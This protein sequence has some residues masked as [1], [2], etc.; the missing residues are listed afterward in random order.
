MVVVDVLWSDPKVNHGCTMNIFRGGGVYF[1]PDVT[2]HFLT[3]SNLRLL[4]RSHECK[5]DGYEF[6]HNN[7]VLTVFSASN[8]YEM[9][10]NR[11]AYV[12]LLGPDLKPQ[13]VQY[14]SQKRQ[15]RILTLRDEVG[16]VLY[17]F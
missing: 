16:K 13:M 14:S 4:I 8:Y 17:L 3:T 12:K 15:S 10:S 1:G 9:G 11:G 5:L 7:M 2:S 6:C